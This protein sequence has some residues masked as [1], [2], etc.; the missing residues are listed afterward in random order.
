MYKYVHMLNN[1]LYHK[2]I[3]IFIYIYISFFISIPFISINR[4][5]YVSQILAI[6]ENSYFTKQI[7]SQK[8]TIRSKKHFKETL[9]GK[10][11]RKVQKI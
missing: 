1:S 4:L 11:G 3:N 6:F 10:E 5:R 9:A 7:T 2:G 8:I